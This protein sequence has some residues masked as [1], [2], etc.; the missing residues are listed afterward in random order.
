MFTSNIIADCHTH[1]N[2]SHDCDCPLDDLVKSAKTKNINVLTITDHCD[3]MT[4]AKD[5]ILN[6]IELSLSN[7]RSSS[8][9]SKDI[10]LLFGIEIG[11][12]YSD[13]RFTEELLSSYH[14][15]EVIGSVHSVRNPKFNKIYYSEIDFSTFNEDEIYLYLDNYFDDVI[16]MVSV[17]KCDVL[18]HLTCPLRYIVHKYNIPVSLSPFSEKISNILDIIIN[19]KIALEINTSCISNNILMPNTEIL[20]LY[21]EKGGYLVTAGSDAHTKD[22]VGN[23]FYKL[24]QTL[25]ELG[26]EHC[27]Y[28]ENRQPIPYKI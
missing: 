16:H 14:F 17:F 25:K 9:K 4:D 5:N 7:I 24:A 19:R 1:T 2:I 18:A 22:N 26:F 23:G 20:R 13:L 28:Y 27:Y 8:I 21:R 3:I 6:S 11:E 15:D 10:K 12:S